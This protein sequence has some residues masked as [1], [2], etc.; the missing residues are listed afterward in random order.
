MKTAARIVIGVFFIMTGVMHFVRPAPFVEIVPRY[1]PEPVLL[2]YLSG[3]FEIAGGA[4]LF[5]PRV[6]R[7]AGIGLILLLAAVFPANIYMLTDHPFLSGKPVSAWV[8]WMR[9]PLQ[10]VLMAAVWWAACRR[11]KV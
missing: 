11:E 6:R 2:V 4:G 8:L 3:F 5:I 1:L 9:L 7:T 10:G